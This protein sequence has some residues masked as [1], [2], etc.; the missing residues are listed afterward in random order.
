MVVTVRHGSLMAPPAPRVQPPALGPGNLFEGALLAPWFI[1]YRLEEELR[2]ARRYGCPLSIVLLSPMLL[3]G[4]PHGDLKL[5]AGARATRDAARASDLIGW[6]GVDDILVVMPHTAAEGAR[7]AVERW[8]ADMEE[9]AP[10][11]GGLK[12]LI[13]VVPDAARYEDG[14]AL[15]AAAASGFRDA[16]DDTSA[17]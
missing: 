8:R 15:L 9:H 5:Q 4:D 17:R 10:H 16:R 7:T 13:S 11:L 14:E 2:E 3:A 6:Y 1:R 12:W